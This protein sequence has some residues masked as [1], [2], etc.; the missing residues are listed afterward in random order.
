MRTTTIHLAL[1]GVLGIFVL[2]SYGQ[3]PPKR[4]AVRMSGKAIT[5]TYSS[6]PTNGAKIFGDKVPYGEVWS[7]G[8]GAPALLH[9]D[10]AIE[11]QGL[12]VPKGDYTLFAIPDP[13]EWQ[14]IVS[15]QGADASSYDGAK[16]VGRV[17]MDMKKA[18]APVEE[19][20]VKLSALGTVACKLEISWE[21]TVASVP[22]NVDAV[23]ANPEW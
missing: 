8:N 15:T 13:D 2:A 22:C 21:S 1:F 14:L 11:I 6:A 19:L 18:S 16:D 5:V 4:T 3:A 9:T 17:P 12:P 7:V 20:Q 10:V 23:R